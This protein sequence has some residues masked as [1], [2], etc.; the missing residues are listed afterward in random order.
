MGIA[1]KEEGATT[2]AGIT[3]SVLHSKVIQNITQ[4]TI[5]I[6]LLLDLVLGQVKINKNLNKRLL[7]N[8]KVLENIN[9]KL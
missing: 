8:D 1:N 6:N 4:V 3:N 9:S 5:R 7:N 2:M